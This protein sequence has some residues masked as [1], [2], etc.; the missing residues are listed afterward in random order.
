MVVG[1]EKK[2]R[3]MREKEKTALTAFHEGGHAIA[4]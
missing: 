3:V 1:T 2:S 4:T